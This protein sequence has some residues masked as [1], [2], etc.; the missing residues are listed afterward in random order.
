M[1]GEPPGSGDPLDPDGLVG[2]A[3]EAAA[4][5]RMLDGAPR[6]VLPITLRAY[7]GQMLRLA[8]PGPGVRR[9]AQAMAGRPPTAPGQP[10]R[11]S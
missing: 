5:R 10:R 9:T 7:G 6:F 3:A 4:I 2:R 1:P 8:G 11:G